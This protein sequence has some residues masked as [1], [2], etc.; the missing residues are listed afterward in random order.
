MLHKTRDLLVRQRTMLTNALRAHL[1]EYGIISA[2]GVGG[3]GSAIK[4]LHE[5]PAT[6]PRLARFALHGL[7]AQLRSIEVGIEKIEAE[8]LK[9]HREATKQAGCWRPSPVLARSRRAQSPR[10]C[11]TP[12]C[13]GPVAN[14][15][16]G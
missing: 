13:S 10:V 14:S 2:Q 16:P 12:H 4:A 1:A 15:R 11:L 3:V 9:W 7:V 6:L 5:D 8:I